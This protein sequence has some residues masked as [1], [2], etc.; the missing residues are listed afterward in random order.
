MSSGYEDIYFKVP[1]KKNLKL[2]SSVT[3]RLPLMDNES[4]G[5]I[6]VRKKESK[7]SQKV[8]DS[9][10]YQYDV[11]LESLLKMNAAQVAE[12]VSRAFI[13]KAIRYA[14]AYHYFGYPTVN[15]TTDKDGNL[16]FPRFGKTENFQ[17]IDD[18]AGENLGSL[19]EI[20][21]K[22]GLEE[23]IIDKY[24]VGLYEYLRGAYDESAGGYGSFNVWFNTKVDPIEQTIDISKVGVKN[25]SL[26][27]GNSVIR[28]DFYDDVRQNL[29]KTY[30][31]M[32]NPGSSTAM[33]MA[34]STIPYNKGFDGVSQNEILSYDNFNFNADQNA[35]LQ[36]LVGPKGNSKWYYSQ[37]P[38][39]PD[40]EK[41]F[42]TSNL[43]TAYKLFPT[44][45][46]V[47]GTLIYSLSPNIAVD[48]SVAKVWDY[49]IDSAP[50]VNINQAKGNYNQPVQGKDSDGNDPL[51]LRFYVNAVDNTD[52]GKPDNT[53]QGSPTVK[54]EDLQ[55]L[56][57]T[58][59]LGGYYP[60]TIAQTEENRTIDNAYNGGDLLFLPK[61][62]EAFRAMKALAKIGLINGWSTPSSKEYNNGALY[63]T[64]HLLEIYDPDRDGI[65]FGNETTPGAETDENYE[66]AY[67]QS[68]T[69]ESTPLQ[70][71]LNMS[72]RDFDEWMYNEA[73]GFG[74]NS[75]KTGTQ[76]PSPVSIMKVFSDHFCAGFFKRIPNGSWYVLKNYAFANTGKPSKLVFPVWNYSKE[77]INSIGYE[78]RI[79]SSSET[80][81]GQ[82]SSQIQSNPEVLL[83]DNVAVP[84]WVSGLQ[85]Y[86]SI[87]EEYIGYG[88]GLASMGVFADPP[89]QVPLS[90]EEQ[91][92]L[93]SIENEE[94][95][96]FI[97]DNVSEW[98]GYKKGQNWNGSAGLPWIGIDV[99][100]NG[101]PFAEL[102]Y[103]IELDI[104]ESMLL[105]D[106]VRRNVF[107]LGG[108]ALEYEAAGFDVDQLLLA[109]KGNVTGDSLSEAYEEA[110]AKQTGP[111]IDFSE[112]PFLVTGDTEVGQVLPDEIYFEA[113]KV[114]DKRNDTKAVSS[115][116]F[117]NEGLKTVALKESPGP[118]AKNIGYLDNFTLVKVLKESVNGKGD[119]NQIEIVDLRSQREGQVGFVEP[120]DLVSLK[121]PQSPVLQTDGTPA[122]FTISYPKFF[123][124]Q[125]KLEGYSLGETEIIQMSEMARALVPTWWK[126]DEP[127]YH[128]EEGNYYISVELPYQ[129]I[130]SKEDLQS[131]I[132]EAIEKGIVTLLDF[133]N[134]EYQ[135]S[136]VSKLAQTDLAVEYLD[137]N[138]DLRPGSY[139]KMLVRLGGIYLNGFPTKA[140]DLQQLKEQSDK[141]LSLDAAFYQKHLEQAVFGLNKFYIELFASNFSLKGFNIIKEADRLANVENYIKKLLL[142]NEYDLTKPGNH[143][144]DVG[145]TDDY[146]IVYMSYREE[147]SPEK[148]LSIG[149]EAFKNSS[150]FTDKNTMALFYYHRQLRNPTLTWQR[151]VDEYLPEP[152]PEIVAKS[153]G[154]G[155]DYP[156]NR[157]SPP[158]FIAPD[159]GD[160]IENLAA[161]L[162]QQLNIDPRFDLGAFEF[163]LSKFLPPCPKPPA[164]RGNAL[165]KT[166]VDLA[167]DQNIYENLDFL[168]NLTNERDRITE[169]VGDFLTSAGALR[170]IRNKVVNLD[171]LHKYVTSMID[172]PTLYNT[173]CRCFIDLAGI[174]DVTLPNFEMKASGGSAGMSTSAALQGKSKD[175][176]LNMKGP[177]ASVNTD[178]ITIDAADLYCSFCLEVPDLFVRL[179]TTNILQFLIDG[180]LKLLEFIL[181]QLL[182]ELIAA[183][184]EA[185]LTCPDI[186]CPPGQGNLKDYGGQDLNSIVASTG[187]PIQEFFNTCGI[188][189]GPEGQQELQSFLGGVSKTI[190]SGEV[191]DLFDGSADIAVYESVQKILVDYPTIQKELS[192]KTK[193]E[194]FFLCMGLQL[195]IEVIDDIEQDIATKFKD[196]EVCRDILEDTK[197]TLKDK[198]GIVED[199]N[200]ISARAEGTDVE[201]YKTLADIIRKQNDLSTQLPPLFSDGKG[202]I[203][204][205]SEMKIPSMEYAIDKA[206]TS[207]ILPIEV[208]LTKES[209]TFT[210]GGGKRGY[211][212]QDPDLKQVLAFPP[213]VAAALAPFMPNLTNRIVNDVDANAIGGM[214]EFVSIIQSESAIKMKLDSDNLVTLFLKPPVSK[215]QIPTYTDNFTIFVKNERLGDFTITPSSVGGISDEQIKM[216]EKYPLFSTAPTDADDNVYSEQSQYFA[217]LFL[218]SLGLGTEIELGGQTKIV[219]GDSTALSPIR[220]E[221]S[222]NL[223]FLIYKRMFDE[224]S[225][226][227][228]NG[229][230]LKKFDANPFEDLNEESF[231]SASDRIANSLSGGITS[232]LSILGDIK[233][234]RSEIENIDFTPTN[235][236]VP[237][238]TLGMIN[239]PLV[240]EVIKKNYDFSQF[241]DPNSTELGMPHFAMLEGLTV[242][243]VQMFVA[244][245]FAKSIFVISKIPVNFFT[246]DYSLADVIVKEMDLFMSQE[247]PKDQASFYKEV[248]LRVISNKSEWEFLDSEN[249]DYNSPGRIYDASLAN[250]VVVYNWKDAAKYFIRQYYKSPIVFIK[251][252]LNKTELKDNGVAIAGKKRIEQ[253][254]PLTVLS[255]PNIL[256]IYDGV[257]SEEVGTSSIC[258]AERI[259]DFKDGKFFYQYYYE[260][261]DWDENDP[262]YNQKL[263]SARKKNGYN[264]KL[265]AET[266]RVFLTQL[267]LGAT[268][269]EQGFEPDE[270]LNYGFTSEYIDKLKSQTGAE[271]WYNV[272][273]NDLFKDIRIGVRYCFGYA[274]TG[275]PVLSNQGEFFNI[276]QNETLQEI[277]KTIFNLNFGN[278]NTNPI[279]SSSTSKD[280][281]EL[282]KTVQETIKREKSIR[283]VEN[284]NVDGPI[285]FGIPSERISYIF[286][287]FEKSK[288]IS[289]WNQGLTGVAETLT[290]D[291][292][293][294]QII[295]GFNSEDMFSTNGPITKNFGDLFY[296]DRI[297]TTTFNLLK[298]MINSDDFQLLYKYAFSVPKILYT[299]SIYT[300]L[301]VSAQN[302]FTPEGEVA[303]GSVSGQRL[304]S[305]FNRTKKSIFEQ[306]KMVGSIRGSESYKE[307]PDSIK[308]QGGPSGI[309]NSNIK[310]A[311]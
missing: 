137:Y 217:G 12:L 86:P 271:K 287:I 20:A 238:D 222:N 99:D 111:N 185:L 109:T 241:Y 131:K 303:S 182:L 56:G 212:I 236:N 126:N 267:Y 136:D 213:F 197:K 157:C 171:D 148:K 108:T 141:V 175:E 138:V 300:I 113:Q 65:L 120:K 239:F 243:M 289:S 37:Q 283:L 280:I 72:P 291:K 81:L 273:L 83:Q 204:I 246:D 70:G 73:N 228:S 118:R 190:S 84:D 260:I 226:A 268:Y 266:M 33:F 282:E 250:E 90:N 258:A 232:L 85:V 311:P 201:K 146:Q 58:N 30:A 211:V 235:S 302:T 188:V 59:Y 36:F 122:T 101:V 128:R 62:I 247:V 26:G 17:G 214:N 167:G 181:T 80:E 187:V 155:F 202:N 290:F 173:L 143:V 21:E 305:A 107:T 47:A 34:G 295:H 254:N 140:D 16:Y 170:D 57:F 244:D 308:Q 55:T 52:L 135:P 15:S 164:G 252:R 210:K 132:P 104:D 10:V 121:P 301:A 116:I 39:T 24:R 224:I 144:I 257:K 220:N 3:M 8:S 74:T 19:I 195:P 208:N 45:A 304:N 88:L 71:V 1:T 98:K 297:Q 43:V 96:N 276:N 38:G 177:Q 159:F 102:R 69:I 192:S 174:D 145:F 123:N 199:A 309:A 186:Q 156:S 255:Y 139:V 11:S 67:Y 237:S 44:E 106:M 82:F 92:E 103:S 264:G 184:L 216:L 129:C 66:E 35:T 274:Y 229:E 2:K 200:K 219:F 284:T 209:K 176:I 207:L 25:D 134:K 61:N 269:Q 105:T 119:Y 225:K 277:Q 112:F 165:F 149:F 285:L 48:Q 293:L 27:K 7:H 242:A 205:M 151:M 178:P 40:S 29:T 95:R 68:E 150:P 161:K 93:Y 46:G 249:T 191:L 91:N 265:S 262:L 306:M 160:I 292:G 166:T 14:L 125:F 79:D 307:E 183:L 275:D 76:I 286:P 18:A 240:K 9:G 127:Y 230:L 253:L 231:A 100:E 89:S 221:I 203:G 296:E 153:F 279:F 142:L 130:T 75:D 50:L 162:D 6:T 117:S 42:K 206:A 248:L 63:T 194:D 41:D 245:F 4:Y 218:K 281:N 22:A 256:E 278:A 31:K 193:I 53:K 78:R 154:D 299:I 298:E 198:C 215:N 227:I 179:P 272:P 158:S 54:P 152:K 147:G 60:K 94:Y 251:D 288:S 32:W 49:I 114:V 23:N 163:S 28:N 310:G 5:S 51:P 180:L 133:Y 110:V 196:P 77:D 223:F 64:N 87:S 259:N 294:Y 13:P 172:V 124:D 169:Y 261:V 234:Y 263:I 189:V 233:I 97:F 168:M 270:S 115:I